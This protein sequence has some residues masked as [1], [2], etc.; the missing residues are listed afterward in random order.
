[1]VGPCDVLA[2]AAHPDDTELGCGATLA[3]LAAAGKRVGMVDL[4][5]GEEATRGTVE[6]REAEAAAAARALGVSWRACL[7]LPD[8]GVAAHDGEQL[9]KVVATLR[10]TAPRAVLIPHPGDPHPDHGAAAALLHRGVFVAALARWRPEL[11]APHRPRLLLAYPGPRQL[12]QPDLVVD[13]SA[14]YPAK[15]AALAAHASQFDPGA[16]SVTHLA[17]GYFLAAIE[18][19]DRACGNTTGY[20]FAEGFAAIG[21]L[22]ADEIAWLL[23]GSRC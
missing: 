8:G 23:G 22:A 9:A 21:P 12:W 3:R 7:A 13:V 11:G 10:A 5:R 14:N 1:M 20:E 6:T 17:S 16:G 2:V 15:R 18:G 4:T 19:R